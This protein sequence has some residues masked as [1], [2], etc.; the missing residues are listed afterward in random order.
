MAGR[1]SFAFN[2]VIW[3]SGFGWKWFP[4][5]PHFLTPL[6]LNIVLFIPE[7]RFHICLLLGPVKIA[8]KAWNDIQCVSGPNAEEMVYL[9][10]LIKVPSH[11]AYCIAENIS[12][13]FLLAI[14]FSIKNDH[15][16]H[17]ICYN[18]DLASGWVKK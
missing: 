16:H 18:V 6:K 2:K 9:V 8:N 5:S 15:L 13:R 4:V 17:I 3:I 10:S 11:R 1:I 12:W 7:N 14:F